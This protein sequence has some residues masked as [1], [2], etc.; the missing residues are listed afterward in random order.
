MLPIYYIN[1][2]TRPDRRRFMEE[3]LQ[4]LGLA[5]IR[6]EAATPSDI[7]AEEAALYCDPHKPVYLRPKELACT[8]S[9]ERVW[10]SMLDARH[11]RA[12]V[13]EDDAELSPALPSF[14]SDIA[15]VEADLIRI[16]SAGRPLR[17]FPKTLVTTDKI[18]LH[19]LKSTPRGTAAYIVTDRGAR[20]LIRHP[21]F[22][23]AQTD[24]VLFNAFGEPAT[25]LTR[26]QAV[27]A[28]ARQLADGRKQ[29]DAEGRSDID[30]RGDQH[31]FPLQQ[32]VQY[33][34]TRLKRGLADGWR[35]LSDHVS[36][37]TKGLERRQV[38]FRDDA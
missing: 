36:S 8:L 31:M 6:I 18:A 20:R 16:E 25:S 14:L 24:L 37:L 35:N 38:L 21:A 19:P 26:L 2:A 29:K 22:R 4:R 11:P 33:R 28:L 7:S 15:G 9:H 27:P 34:L 32:P 13:L 10:Q 30:Q 3:Q 17:L 23:A 5:G 12:L 1:L